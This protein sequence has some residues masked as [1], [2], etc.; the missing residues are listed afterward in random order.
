MHDVCRALLV[1]TLPSSW[2]GH[3]FI[4]ME[5]DYSLEDELTSSCPWQITAHQN[6]GS[7]L[8]EKSLH[9]MEGRIGKM[10][11][12]LTEATTAASWAVAAAASVSRQLQHSMTSPHAP[13]GGETTLGLEASISGQGAQQLP[14][15]E[16]APQSP[17][18]PLLPANES[19][20]SDTD[21]MEFTPW[22]K[23]TDGSQK[24][25]GHQLQHPVGSMLPFTPVSFAALS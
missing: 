12:R 25:A 22:R 17:N 8:V 24:E 1:Q 21:E 7:N 13:D 10:E 4:A 2:S 11:E 23:S 19:F 15:V 18:K 20:R 9:V 6:E 3:T 14:P 16:S 5:L